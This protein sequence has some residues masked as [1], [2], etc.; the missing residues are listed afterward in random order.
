MELEQ[1]M[2]LKKFYIMDVPHLD[3]QVNYYNNKYI[4]SS[5]NYFKIHHIA[6]VSR[7]VFKTNPD[8]KPQIIEVEYPE[9]VNIPPSSRR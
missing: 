9:A 8:S 7:K 2:S 6:L 5:R 1:P 3:G 4:I